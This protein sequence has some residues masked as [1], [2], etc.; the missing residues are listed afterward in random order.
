M[1]RMLQGGCNI[2]AL[3]MIPSEFEYCMSCGASDKPLQRS[4]FLRTKHVVREDYDYD[5][6]QNYCYMCQECHLAFENLRPEY[7]CNYWE[8]KSKSNTLDKSYTD[9]C[10]LFIERTKYLLGEGLEVTVW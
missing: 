7:R 2:M 9:K 5:D 1:I 4:H 3:D 8:R 10:I 6:I